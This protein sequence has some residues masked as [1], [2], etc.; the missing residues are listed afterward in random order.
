[1]PQRKSFNNLLVLAAEKVEVQRELAPDSTARPRFREYGHA[2][3]YRRVHTALGI[4]DEVGHEHGGAQTHDGTQESVIA[5]VMKTYRF[6]H[7]QLSGIRRAGKKLGL[8]ARP[9][10][11]AACIRG[12]R[13]RN[14]HTAV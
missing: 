11:V 10:I 4:L 6:E 5:C 12:V 3:T 13:E 2:D 14:N 9:A 1:M 8:R 7:Q